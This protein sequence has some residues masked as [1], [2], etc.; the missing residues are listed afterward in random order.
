MKIW[1]TKP[2]GTLWAT[3]G[4]LRDC[5]IW[6]ISH[7]KDNWGKYDQKCIF[8]HVKYSLCISDSNAI[9]ILLTDFPKNIEISN[10]MIIRPEGT[11]LFRADRRTDGQ[12]WRSKQ[13]L[14]VNLRMSL[15]TPS[16]VWKGMLDCSPTYLSTQNTTHTHTKRY[17]ASSPQITS[18]VLK[19]L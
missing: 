10:F 4:L 2:P 16:F 9:G 3:P 1:E 12:T 14:F 11:E 19:N 6:D 7:S 5:F 8:F 17:A 13:L 18:T 15:K